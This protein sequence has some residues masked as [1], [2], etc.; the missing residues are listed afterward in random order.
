[1]YTQLPQYPRNQPRNVLN[2]TDGIALMA[3]H[4]VIGSVREARDRYVAQLT[5]A[6]DPA[7]DVPA[8]RSGPGSGPPPGPQRRGG[9][10]PGFGGVP[11]LKAPEGAARVRAVVP[12]HGAE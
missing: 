6:V 10:P 11:S 2:S 8:H 12:G 7:A 5:M 9:P 1:M 3:G 4:T